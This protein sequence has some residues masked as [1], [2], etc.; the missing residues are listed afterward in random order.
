MKQIYLIR[1]AQSEANA[2]LVIR[3]NHD[4]ALTSLGH[5]QATE[6][7]D[8]LYARVPKPDGVFISEMIRTHQ[9]AAPYL[10]R[11]HQQAQMLADLSEFNYLDYGRICNLQFSELL[12]IADN[13]WQQ[14]DV[15]FY[16]GAE[17]DSYCDFVKRVAQMR[18]YFHALP[19]GV[20]VAFTHGMWLGMLM[21][22]L[23]LK[24]DMPRLMDMRAFRQFEL[25]IRPKNCEVF[26]LD[27]QADIDCQANIATITK[28]RAV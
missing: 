26:R 23:L 16:D 5:T 17:T 14:A 1:H 28:L 8:W 11:S 13:Y 25:A 15:D 7:A 4:I 12:S 22:Q 3:P 24:D 10:T 27:C 6:V 2:G 9:T 19:D 18:A 20:Y 21:W